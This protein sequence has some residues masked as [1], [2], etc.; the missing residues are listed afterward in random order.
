MQFI[1]TKDVLTNIYQILGFENR[2]LRSTSE[3]NVVF[4]LDFG[5]NYRVYRILSYLYFD[6]NCFKLQRKYL[7]FRDLEDRVPSIIKKKVETD[8]LTELGV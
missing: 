2:K 5:G 3:E 1:G 6:R 8:E 7:R 4:R